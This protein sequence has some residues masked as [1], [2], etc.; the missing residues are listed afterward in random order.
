MEGHTL[1]VGEPAGVLGS[2][3]EEF[4]DA[5]ATLVPIELVVEEV[6]FRVVFWNL[7]IVV[8]SV[9][10][11]VLVSIQVQI[12]FEFLEQGQEV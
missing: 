8:V 1:L 2:G 10:D 6:A 7:V 11:H 4:F 5:L 12:K 3:A 9:G